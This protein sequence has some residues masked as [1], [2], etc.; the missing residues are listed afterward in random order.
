MSAVPIVAV[1]EI[2][3]GS[4]RPLV[5][6]LSDEGELRRL[7]RMKSCRILNDP[8]LADNPRVRDLRISQA[9]AFA[10]QFCKGA[11]A[12]QPDQVRIVGT[13]WIR[14]LESADRQRFFDSLNNF[15]ILSGDQEAYFSAMAALHALPTVGATSVV[16]VIDQG[17]GSCE[18]AMASGV[19]ET[20]NV[21]K[22]VSY[23]FGSNA[24]M[25]MF[26]SCRN[27]LSGY[28]AAIKKR[29]VDSAIPDWV[30]SLTRVIVQGSPVTKFASLTSRTRTSKGYAAFSV[31]GMES[32]VERLERFVYKTQTESGKHQG[33]MESTLISIV[34]LIELLRAIRVS[35][36]VVS[37][38]GTR[39]GIVWSGLLG[40]KHS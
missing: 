29:I 7:D 6:T 28:T 20:F 13:G 17:Y 31:H 37:S 9:I 38:S 22:T 8:I 12:F 15:E 5:A 14:D 19:R 4:V 35:K 34:F 39:F 30:P 40:L 33:E 36:I 26:R 11:A 24:L 18:L 32:S 2:G 27:D 21:N 1:I 10:L 3:T 16:L 25:K 23:N